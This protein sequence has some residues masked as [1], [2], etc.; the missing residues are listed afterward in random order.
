MGH[1]RGAPQRRRR[2]Q[3][4]LIDRPTAQARCASTRSPTCSSRR[5]RTSSSTR[6]CP[7]SIDIGVDVAGRDVDA[8]A[9]DIDDR[10]RKH[11]NF[12][13]EYHAELLDDY[14]G[15]AVG[16]VTFIGVSLAVAGRASSSCCRRRSAAGG[17]RRWCSWPCR[18][19]SSGGVLA[20]LID[21][22][23]HDRLVRRVPRGLRPGARVTHR[24]GSS[25]RTTARTWT[26][27]TF[28]PEHSCAAPRA[29]ASRPTFTSRGR[30][31]CRVPGSRCCSS[32]A[33]RAARSCIRWR[34]SS[35]AASS[36]RPS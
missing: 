11:R 21:G 1:A 13:L 28:G 20:A 9:S 8:V 6:R 17:W 30:G 27:R 33:V 31:R 24:L 34:W 15:P 36:R 3:S 32:A 35:S 19:R 7:G 18:P 14:R 29:T 26:V 22:D 5:A 25:R 10:I 23:R 2:P 16:P 12:P 4:L